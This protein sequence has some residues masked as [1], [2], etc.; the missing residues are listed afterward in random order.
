MLLSRRAR[1]LLRQLRSG[2]RRQ[3]D[4]EAERTVGRPEGA[5]TQT[6]EQR[7][8][9][10]IS[11]AERAARVAI[12]RAARA[13]PPAPP[14]G[15][16]EELVPGRIV[17]GPDG[18]FYLVEARPAEV[19]PRAA[20][21]LEG[22]P[23]SLRAV[24]A[25]SGDAELGRLGEATPDQLA[26]LD[27]ETAGL[28]AAP[29]FLVGLVLWANEQPDTAVVHQ[30]MARDY[31]EEAAV[32]GEAARLLAGR[33]VL[34]SFNGRAFDLPLMQ[35]RLVYHR[36]QRITPPECHLDLLGLARKRFRG[37][38]EDCRLQ[39]LEKHLCGRERWGD[40]EGADIPRAYHDFVESGDA[41]QM[42]LVIE[43]NRLD[44]I[45][46]LEILPHLGS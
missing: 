13:A 3:S 8:G 38:W 24:S 10:S 29:I 28:W 14:S 46:M 16:L 36:L 12:R 20:G 39:T 34:I 31:A 9:Q 4:L 19:H 27:L 7:T 18:S 37:R 32:L 25:A 21:I 6:T 40:I 5:R 22:L 30:L 1:Q 43:H 15:P 11:V 33:R 45:S 42:K 26:L 23:D 35:E 17:E 44:L 41:G 2:G